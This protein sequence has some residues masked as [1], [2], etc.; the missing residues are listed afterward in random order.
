MR[1]SCLERQPAIVDLHN[2]KYQ[3]IYN[4]EQ[5]T[6]NGP[7]G[8]ETHW[9]Y[10]YVEVSANEE[11]LIISALIHEQHSV[12]DEI[13]LINNFNTGSQDAI[14]EYENYQNLRQSIKELVKTTL[15][16]DPLQ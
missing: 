1:Q 3:F 11:G 14:E 13:A 7:N 15:L 4:Q 12:D 16:N 5:V 8:P 10:D 9:E 2:G 6:F